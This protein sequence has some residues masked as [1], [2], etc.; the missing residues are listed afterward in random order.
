VKLAHGW[1]ARFVDHSK[2]VLCWKPGAANRRVCYEYL[3][4]QVRSMRRVDCLTGTTLTD[5]FNQVPPACLEEIVIAA[6]ERWA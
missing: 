1:N 5:N 6:R 3:G 4:L 2:R